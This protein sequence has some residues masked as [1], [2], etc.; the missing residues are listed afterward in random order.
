MRALL[1]AL[2]LLTVPIAALAQAPATGDISERPDAALCIVKYMDPN[3]GAGLRTCY[4]LDPATFL[5]T[6]THLECHPYGTAG[7]GITNHQIIVPNG[8]GNVRVWGVIVRSNPNGAPS[9]SNV[10]EFSKEC[11]DV[12]MQPI[13][14][15]GHPPLED[16]L[17]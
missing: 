17:A 2:L 5:D 16:S 11:Q 8:Q 3:T 12:P 10:S 14:L 6:A 15:S 4:V 7:P 9:I 13:Q 1:L